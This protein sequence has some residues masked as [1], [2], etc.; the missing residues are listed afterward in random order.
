VLWDTGV[1][2]AALNDPKGWSTLPKLIVYHLDKTITD[3][4]AES[5]LRQVTSPMLRYPILTATI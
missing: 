2:Q 1:P 3:Q 5:G 4:L